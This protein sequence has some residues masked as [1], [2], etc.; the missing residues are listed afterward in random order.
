MKLLKTTWEIIKVDLMRHSEQILISLIKRAPQSINLF[1]FAQG[2]KTYNPNYERD[3]KRHSLKIAHVLSWAVSK[4]EKL[5]ELQPE[6]S[7]LG[8]RHRY[9]GMDLRYILPMEGVVMELARE[10]LGDMFSEEIRDSWSLFLQT[11]LYLTFQPLLRQGEKRRSRGILFVN[12]YRRIL[13]VVL[14]NMR[15]FVILSAL[16]A[17]LVGWIKVIYETWYF[18]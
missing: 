11:L 18:C 6:L 15:V 12:F 3:I 17:L 2:S 5:Q 4:S 16:L 1:T 13:T 7:A 8:E 9:Y 14:T 10:Y